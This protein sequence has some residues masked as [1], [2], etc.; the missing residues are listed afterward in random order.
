MVRRILEVFYRRGR[1]GRGRSWGRVLWREGVL[2][3][4]LF[5]VILFHEVFKG[6]A[7]RRGFAFG[8]QLFERWLAEFF[9]EPFYGGLQNGFIP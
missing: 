9:R 1:W 4:Y 2:R 6:S 3:S 7:E 8:H 5:L